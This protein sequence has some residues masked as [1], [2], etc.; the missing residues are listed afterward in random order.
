ML[1]QVAA[2]TSVLVFTAGQLVTVFA[3]GTAIGTPLIMVANA[4]MN[5]LRQLLMSLGIIIFGI[6]AMLTL[7]A[8]GFL[9][10]SRIVIGVGTGVFVVSVYAIAAKL[11]VR[12]RQGGAMSTVAMRYSSSLV[13][14]FPLV[15]S[16]PL[17]TIG[18]PFS[19]PLE[20]SVCWPSSL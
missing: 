11:A 17:R 16:S 2:S 5:Q 19:G 15:A 14:G 7:P 6:A 4:K 12:G 9:M 3:L 10:A 18:R 20:S 8:F 13:F 1:N